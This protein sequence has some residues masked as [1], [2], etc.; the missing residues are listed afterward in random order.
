MAST[1]QWISILI[2]WRI[3]KWPQW[4]GVLFELCIIKWIDSL[5]I[6]NVTVKGKTLTLLDTLPF[7]IAQKCTKSA[8]VQMIQNGDEKMFV[9]FKRMRILLHHLPNTV[10]KLQKDGRS[11]GIRMMVVSMADS[12][13]ELMTKGKPLFFDQNFESFDGSIV[14]VQ[15]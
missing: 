6:W 14:W 13:L 5:E 2:T 8:R 11:I 10:D 12:L 3:Y 4:N 1:I 15:Q 7:G 9:E